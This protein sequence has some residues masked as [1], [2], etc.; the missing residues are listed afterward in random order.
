MN[1]EAHNPQPADSHGAVDLSAAAAAS[2]PTPGQQSAAQG[3]PSGQAQVPP[4]G[5]SIDIP[6]V[7]TCDDST[8]EAVAAHSQQVPVVLVLWA[9]QSLESKQLLATMEE[10]ARD[11]AG[12]FQLVEIDVA[13]SQRI[14]QAFQVQ[15]IPTVVALVGA[16][17]VPL[18][19]GVAA[20]EQITPVIDDLL[21]A[22]Q[23]MGVTGRVAVSGQDVAKPIPEEH[24]PAL[25][26]EERGD[27]EAARA[28]WDKI[29]ELNPRDEDA[30]D[31]RAR[32]NLRM[33]ESQAGDDPSAQADSLFAAGQ[34]REAFELLL[35]L[36]EDASEE[37]AE[38]YRVRLLDL[39]RIAGNTPDVK[40][41]RR[42]LS[43]LLMI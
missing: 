33:R 41:A 14:A 3:Y 12:A 38:E 21:R 1:N 24:I 20:K 35:R 26:A 2:A 32:V 11:K 5:V 31:H 29:I 22:A 39:F 4:Q 27:F 34:H 42:R 13:N 6:L 16:R 17:P 9:A 36:L 23:Q 40:A 37:D 8:F 30:K 43:A 28:A 7:D 19:Q 15:V 18:F 25:E 10:L